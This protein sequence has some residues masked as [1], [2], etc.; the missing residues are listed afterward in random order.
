MW[1]KK[2]KANEKEPD[3]PLTTALRPLQLP[4][5]QCFPTIHTLLR[6]ISRASP[7]EIALQEVWARTREITFPLWNQLLLMLL[8]CNLTLCS[9][10]LADSSNNLPC[11]CSVLPETEGQ[12]LYCTSLESLLEMEA[13]TTNSSLSQRLWAMLQESGPVSD[14]V[15]EKLRY[16]VGAFHSPRKLSGRKLFLTYGPM[17]L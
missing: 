4:S 5:A 1:C 11:A 7:T 17:N 16:T 6:V 3:T 9:P 13:S 12:D 15:S 14:S 8:V 10:S 2:S